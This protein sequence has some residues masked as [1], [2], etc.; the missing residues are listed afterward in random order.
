MCRPDPGG[1]VASGLGGVE[2]RG[3]IARGSV[4]IYLASRNRGKLRDFDGMAPALRVELL[5]AIEA[6]PETEETGETFLANACLKAAASSRWAAESLAGRKPGASAPLGILVM[7]DDSGL[8]VDALGGAPGVYSARYA[9]RHGDDE[10]N[11]RLVLEK[12]RGLPLEKRRARF[13]CV[14][15][16]ARAGEVLATFAGCAEG[17][18][19][20]QPRG[21]QGFGYDP[22]F[23]SPA[24]GR[25]FAELTAAEKSRFSHRGQAARALLQWARNQSALF[26]EPRGNI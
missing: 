3:E 8:E 6:M 10:A 1:E 17:Y 15:A 19:L 9:G 13:V 11:N 16:V 23:Y 21:S 4:K 7:A 24:A 20:E 12:L 18:I 25:G 14:L 22:L 5:P 26:S 2:P